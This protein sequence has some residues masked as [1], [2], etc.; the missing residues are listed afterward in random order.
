ML[1]LEFLKS[2]DWITPTLAS[3]LFVGTNAF[4]LGVD[5]G[6]EQAIVQ[7]GL[8]IVMTVVAIGLRANVTMLGSY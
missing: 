6:I 8:G 2:V 7:F 4:L 5:M 3:A 1:S